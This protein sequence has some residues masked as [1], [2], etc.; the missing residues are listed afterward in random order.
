MGSLA[1]VYEIR[2]LN[3]KKIYIGSSVDLHRRWGDHKGLL[4][5]KKHHN[6]H[7]Q[8]SWIKHGEEAFVFNTILRC[9]K[10][11][12]LFYEQRA[13]DILKPVYNICPTAGNR[14]GTKHTKETLDKLKGH[15]VSQITREKIR[16]KRAMQ[17]FSEETKE[18]L[19]RYAT[20]RVFSDERRMNISRA[21]KGRMIS[22]STRAKL[23]AANLGKKLS[24]EHRRNMSISHRMRRK[25]C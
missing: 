13:I 17:I 4:R 20:G 23:R 12:L 14:E 24:E 11:M 2:N 19:R 6:T 16:A 3:T 15:P 5:N 21:L 8:S 7:L 18:K 9:D 1:G 22:E 25:G 10:N